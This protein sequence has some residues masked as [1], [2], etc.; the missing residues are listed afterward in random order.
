MKYCFLLFLI[1][2]SASIAVGQ[3]ISTTEWTRFIP[4]ESIPA[5]IS[6]RSSNN[7]LDVIRFKDNYYVAFRTAPTHFASK[8]TVIYIISS[9]DLKSWKKETEFFVNADMREPRFIEF[10]NQLHFYFFEGGTKMFKFEPKHIW[11]SRLTD[12]GWTAKIK[13]NLDGFVNW[14][15]RTY[16]N[17]LYLSAYYGVNLYKNDHQADLRLFTSENGIQFTP[18]SKEPQISTKGAEEGEFIFDKSG[19]LWATVRLEGSGSYLC[20][21]SKDSIDKWHTTFSKLKYDSALMFE[22]G[23]DIYLVSRRHLKGNA[24]EVEVPDKKQRRKNLLRYSFSKKVTALFKINKEKMEIEHVMDFPSTG[25]TAFPGIASIDEH[26]FYLLNYSSDI[27]KRSKIWIGGQLGKTYIYQ[28]KL[29][30][31]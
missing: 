5:S 19:N 18:I 23:E 20:F 15:F 11:N 22:K 10:N 24:T 8:K 30:I 1:Y 12:T 31:K 25:D 9:A 2:S 28:T 16:N 13:T 7:N 3:T 6:C 14:R 4:S 26:T 27:N 21:A 17:Q 29:I